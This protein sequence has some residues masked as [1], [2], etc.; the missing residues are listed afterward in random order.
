MK[1]TGHVTR[2]GKER[3]AYRLL[4]RKPEGKSPLVRSRRRWV[5]IRIYLGD[6]WVMWTGLVWLRIG[7]SGELL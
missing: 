5:D 3:N 7:T 4:V 1:W 6:I 2:I